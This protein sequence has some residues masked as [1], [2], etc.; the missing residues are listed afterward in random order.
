[1]VR[2]HMP[3]ASSTWDRRQ[4]QPPAAPLLLVGRPD[5]V[6][7]GGGEKQALGGEGPS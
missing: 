4:G 7:R 2:C 3:A 1:M 5:L 6:V